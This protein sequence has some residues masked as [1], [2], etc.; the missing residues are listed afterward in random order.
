MGAAVNWKTFSVSPELVTKLICGA[1]MPAGIQGDLR[2]VVLE[3]ELEVDGVPAALR[4]PGVVVRLG[5][6]RESGVDDLTRDVFGVDRAE[7]E[8]E[9]TVVPETV[10]LALRGLTRR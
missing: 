8:E 10:N 4:L 6:K 2:G 9:G 3:V 1:A 5:A 7:D